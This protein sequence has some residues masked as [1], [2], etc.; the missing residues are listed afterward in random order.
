M[1]D[2]SVK[3]SLFRVTFFNKNVSKKF[4]Q[5][6]IYFSMKMSW[7]INKSYKGIFQ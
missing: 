3:M 5:K 4:I 2:F 7:Q 1:C 6:R